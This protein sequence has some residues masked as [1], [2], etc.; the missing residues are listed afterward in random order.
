MMPRIK[1]SKFS[2]LFLL[3]LIANINISCTIFFSVSTTHCVKIE[4]N[5]TQLFAMRYYQF[6]S[7][8]SYRVITLKIVEAALIILLHARYPKPDFFV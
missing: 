5:G 2:A 1:C 6:E 8:T 3:R 4:K 7:T